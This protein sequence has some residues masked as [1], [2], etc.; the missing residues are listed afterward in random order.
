MS[1]LSKL[2]GDKATATPEEAPVAAPVEDKTVVPAAA[3]ASKPETDNTVAEPVIKPEENKTS[4]EPDAAPDA[5]PE[6]QAQ[7][8]PRAELAELAEIV[9]SEF[10]VNAFAKGMT[11]PETI[12]AHHAS[13]K[14]ENERLRAVVEKLGGETE[15][16]QAQSVSPED[17]A[18]AKAEKELT[19][20][21][22]ANRAKI[23]AAMAAKR[24]KSK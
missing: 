22:G 2:R 7:T 9:G 16:A 24:N 6:A 8:N 21:L 3:P 4:P 5:A 23:A 1:L 10:A 20:A 17:E 19:P 12:E 15:P 11:R 13:L 14:A 18:R